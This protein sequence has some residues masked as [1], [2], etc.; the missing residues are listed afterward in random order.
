MRVARF[1]A[2]PSGSFLPDNS[3]QGKTNLFLTEIMLIYTVVRSVAQLV[4]QRSPKPLV[5]GSNPATPAS[6]RS[7]DGIWSDTDSYW[8]TLAAHKAGH[9]R[10]F[11]LGLLLADSFDHNRSEYGPRVAW[12]P[13]VLAAACVA[14]GESEQIIPMPKWRNGRRAIL[15]GW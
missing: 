3:G 5:A 15:R 7:I 2:Q 9:P 14:P 1:R 10:R 13:E 4:E 6:I 12:A 8:R 11:A